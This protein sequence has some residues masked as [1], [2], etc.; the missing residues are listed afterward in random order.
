MPAAS[1]TT[2]CVSVIIVVIGKGGVKASTGVG[3]MLGVTLGVMVGA[4][5]LLGVSV[6][7]GVIAVGVIVTS[8]RAVASNVADGLGVSVSVGE[9]GD[10]WGCCRRQIALFCNSHQHITLVCPLAVQD[11]CQ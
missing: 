7:V 1:L 9:G 4:G 6:T 2:V 3:V 10:G 8:A 11:N 5:V